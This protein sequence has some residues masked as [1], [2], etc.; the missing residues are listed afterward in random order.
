MNRGLHT[1]KIYADDSGPGPC[2]TTRN[3]SLGTPGASGL[4]H[5]GDLGACPRNLNT[6]LGALRHYSDG[7]LG[8][9]ANP[10]RTIGRIQCGELVWVLNV[11]DNR[12]RRLER[13]PSV[14]YSPARGVRRRR[15]AISSQ[16]REVSWGRR[17]RRRRRELRPRP[18]PTCHDRR[19]DCQ[20]YRVGVPGP[21]R[22]P[23]NF[24]EFDAG[25]IMAYLRSMTAVPA[26]IAATGRRGPRQTVVEGKGQCLTCHRVDGAGS[27]LGPASGQCRAAAARRRTAAIAHSIRKRRSSRWMGRPR[28][29]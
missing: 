6:L 1:T 25:R 29:H 14:G 20:D 8:R 17:R 13:S 23:G 22:P 16:L 21:A 19:R 15:P 3:S 24:S 27:Q 18:V 7:R 5:S 28:G 26:A 12:G 2:A 4:L 9:G 11:S 10:C